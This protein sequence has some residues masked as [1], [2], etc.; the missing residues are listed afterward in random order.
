MD[1][2]IVKPKDVDA[3]A[4]L[5]NDRPWVKQGTWPGSFLWFTAILESFSEEWTGRVLSPRLAIQDY[6]CIGQPHGAYDCL[7]GANCFSDLRQVMEDEYAELGPSYFRNYADICE[8]TYEEWLAFSQSVAEQGNELDKL[9]NLELANLLHQ[10]FVLMRE[11]GNFQDT[12]IVLADFLGDVV[13]S[14]IDEVLKKYGIEDPRAYGLFL[15][16]HSSSPR[17]TNLMESESSIRAMV[18]MIRESTELYSLFNTEKPPK[19]TDSLERDRKSLYIALQDHLYRFGWLST[20][21]FSGEPFTMEQ[22]V[23]LIQGRLEDLDT[24]E[25]HQSTLQLDATT[26]ELARQLKNIDVPRELQELLEVTSLLTYINSAKDDVHQITWRDIQILTKIVASRLGCTV[27]DLTLLTPQ[28]LERALNEGRAH[29]DLLASREKGWALLKVGDMLHIVQGEKELETLR[30]RIKPILPKDVKTLTGRAIFPG[31]VRGK[32]RLVLT[33]QDC[34]K[35]EVGDI[36]VATNTNPDFIP[37]MHRAAAFV[38]DTGNLICHAVIAAR[39][40]K[41]TCV[42]STQIATQILVDGELVEVDGSAGTVTRL[43]AL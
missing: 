1:T 21:S 13:G 28:E 7:I 11:N 18:Q 35:V 10:Y 23:E 3:V 37:A 36:L 6:A 29:R 12:I 39:E 33:S 40:F 4:K 32:A 20:Y 42:I 17:P 22:I 5:F 2:R 26:D 41:K 43:G 25:E 9:S 19:I 8:K 16:I 31:I 14:S 34:D 30:E 27:H 15:E 24:S 38:T